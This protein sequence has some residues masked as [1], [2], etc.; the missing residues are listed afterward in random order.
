MLGYIIL[1]DK[2]KWVCFAL[3]L[4]T[5][6]VFISLTVVYVRRYKEVKKLLAHVERAYPNE[7][8]D[9]VR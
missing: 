9:A 5:G 7:H 1:V 3:M 2:L 6:L 4:P 8:F